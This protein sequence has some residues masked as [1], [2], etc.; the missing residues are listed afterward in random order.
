[1]YYSRTKFKKDHKVWQIAYL[2]GII[3]GEGCMYLGYNKAH[4]K[5]HSWHSMM[6]V[7]NCDIEL[8]LWLENTFGG[9]KQT[10]TR[11]TSKR[12]FE[13]PVYTWQSTGAMLDYLLPLIQPFLVIKNKQ[14][15]IMLRYR[16]TCG[17]NGPIK[18][19]EE[20][21]KER[22]ECMLLM[23]KLNSRWHN[24]PLKNPS[25]LLP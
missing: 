5:Y 14:C 24:H 11:W 18:I 19:S 21:Q 10:H 23:R 15:E 25:A 20:I 1:M 3:D 16:K 17:W 8:I 2:A 13:R 4:E 12:A 9:A 22:T 6:K 7:S